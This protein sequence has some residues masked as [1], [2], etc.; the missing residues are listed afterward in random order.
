MHFIPC[1]VPLE[2]DSY[3]YDVLLSVFSFQLISR[4]SGTII[5]S[6]RLGIVY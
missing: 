4:S 1:S 6:N 2:N 5:G 3:T